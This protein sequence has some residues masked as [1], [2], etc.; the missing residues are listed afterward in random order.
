MPIVAPIMKVQSCRQYGANIVIH[1]KSFKTILKTL[2]RLIIKLIL[3]NP[4]QRYWRIEGIRYETCQGE[5]V[6]LH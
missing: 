5:I 3:T 4:G 1:V 2:F 6:D